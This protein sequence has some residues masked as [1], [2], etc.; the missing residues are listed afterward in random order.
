MGMIS[1]SLHKICFVS[2]SWVWRTCQ[3]TM[4]HTDK[5]T[6]TKWHLHQ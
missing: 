3:F 5:M 6:P 2:R 4:S 1:V